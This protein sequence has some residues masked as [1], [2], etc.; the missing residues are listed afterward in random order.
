MKNSAGRL[1]LAGAVAAI[2]L[3]AAMP[4]ESE[5]LRIA[6]WGGATQ[7]AE[8]EAYWKPYTAETGVQ[9]IED[10]W[11]GE[12]GKIRA[13]VESGNVTW[14]IVVA[15]YAHA[16][17]GCDEG[18][19]E[20]IEKT[21]FGDLDDF[22]PG[23]LH[24]CGVPELVFSVIFGYNADRIPASWGDGRPTT[25]AD[26]FDTQRWPGK[27]A[28][29]K[30]PKWVLEPAL[31]ADGVPA[32][33]I[34]EVLDTPEGLERALAKLDTIKNDVVWWESGAQPPQLLAD[35]EAVIA[36]MY[37]SRLYDARVNENKNFVAVWDGQ[38]Y[39][40]NSMIIPKGGNREAAMR[41]LEYVVRPDVMARVSNYTSYG[42][43]RVSAMQYVP[44]SI[45]P[46][47]PTSAEH[48]SGSLLSGEEWWAD[49][50]DDVNQRF[51]NWIAK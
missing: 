26:M 23:T 6:S 32:D 24:E 43:A 21:G 48:L 27:R 44:D 31:M 47:L 8:R 19:L 41:Y 46:Y 28:L 38:I 49:H 30:D 13:M 22:L 37:S 16:I 2:V 9:I 4:A 15:D 36:Q 39:S 33:K 34:Y 3:L 35:G 11:N 7:D 25:I 14:D 40:P 50:Y 12:F 29:R 5:T 45:K 1:P 42:P 20:P 51:Q 18:V 17:T 10:T